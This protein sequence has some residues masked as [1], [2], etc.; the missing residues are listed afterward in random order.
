[1]GTVINDW[2]ELAE[3]LDSEKAAGKKVVFTNGVFDIL[4]AGHL[5]SLQS[6]RALGDVLV[7]GINTDESVRNLKGQMRPIINQAERA[8]MLAGLSC[9]DYV[10]IFNDNTPTAL[11]SVVKPDIHCK[12]GDY[13]ISDLPEAS[14]VMKN[15]GEV[16]ILPLLPGRSSTDIISK[17]KQIILLEGGK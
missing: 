14:E 3:K 13:R 2:S 16:V 15:G 9:V 7:V 6:A 12:G 8:E 4:H 1:M 5:R 11:I 17:L 10:S